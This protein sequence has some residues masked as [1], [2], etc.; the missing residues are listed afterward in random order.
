METVQ[1]NA[2]PAIPPW[3]HT[4]SRRRQLGFG[5]VAFIP[6]VLLAATL[7]ALVLTAF[8]VAPRLYGAL[9]ILAYTHV[10]SQFI[11][12]LVVGHLMV[13]NPA[14]SGG[15][16]LVWGFFFLFAAPFAVAAYWLFYIWRADE[17]G[18]PDVVGR[19]VHVYDYDYEG[20]GAV[21]QRRDDD[22][23]LH[24]IDARA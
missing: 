22:A 5:I 14:L 19:H 10:T 11:T 3:P 4:W 9:P 8:G 2:N 1:R 7:L 18:A 23:I 24:H 21:T 17:K 16:K 13:G 20:D 15:M 6:I 12:L